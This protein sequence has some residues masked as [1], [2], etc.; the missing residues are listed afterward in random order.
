MCFLEVLVCIG[1]LTHCYL[2]RCAGGSNCWLG[3]IYGV[4]DLCCNL[5]LTLGVPL[6][7]LYLRFEK[8]LRYFEYTSRVGAFY[9]V[10]RCLEGFLFFVYLFS[11]FNPLS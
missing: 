9:L 11:A 3:D 8:F 4:L 10:F 1:S 7:V 5:F 2:L 6:C